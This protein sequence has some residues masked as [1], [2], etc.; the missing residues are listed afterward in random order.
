MNYQFELIEQTRHN[1][2]SLTHHFDIDE[3]NKIPEG[4]S[5]NLIWNFGHILVTQQLLCY[6]LSELDYLIPEELVNRY[7]KG[8]R[9]V[10]YIDQS[11]FELIDNLLEETY[12]QLVKDY[13]NEI[14]QEYQDY[15]TSYNVTLYSIEEAIQFNAL[16]ETL[17][18]GYALAIK[19][20]LKS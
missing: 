15:T 11:E 4:F 14:F 3:L 2:S 17:H 19:N 18:F 5:N 16:H 8:S 7:R 13:D 12:H 9:P 1:F 10:A 6:H 20:A